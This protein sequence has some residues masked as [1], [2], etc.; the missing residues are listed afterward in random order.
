MI[1]L[2]KSYLILLLYIPP[3]VYYTQ[4]SNARCIQ[5]CTERSDTHFTEDTH[6]VF[7]NTRFS[8]LTPSILHCFSLMH[9]RI[10]VFLSN[11]VLG[12]FCVNLGYLVHRH[13]TWINAKHCILHLP[14]K[15]VISLIQEQPFFP[16]NASYFALFQHGKYFYMSFFQ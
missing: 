10:S 15:S 12:H 3:Y 1:L 8:L 9:I 2:V 7:K 16:S 4:Y 13:D 11:A 5:I 14:K 6:T